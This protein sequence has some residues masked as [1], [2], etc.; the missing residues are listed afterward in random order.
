VAW[1]PPPARPSF[2]A[3]PGL[4][5]L[6]RLRGGTWACPY[7]SVRQA[8][9]GCDD[10]PPSCSGYVFLSS[11]YKKIEE[12]ENEVQEKGAE[13]T[14]GEQQPWLIVCPF[15]AGGHVVERP[16]HCW[17]E[18]KLREFL[19]VQKMSDKW[20]DFT[21]IKR[22]AVVSADVQTSGENGEVS[23]SGC[24]SSRRR[25][26]CCCCCCCREEGMAETGESASRKDRSV[27]CLSSVK[28]GKKKK[29][30]VGWFSTQWRKP[31]VPCY[32]NWVS[33]ADRRS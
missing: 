27:K 25:C 31:S 5:Q 33:W 26:S 29:K 10:G 30:V 8:S 13:N 4:L 18:D 11:P 2:P 15:L 3:F 7:T 12:R 19:R 20:R 32:I 17:A 9:G 21:D 23:G 22:L 28:K 1:L 16:E 14:Q 24:C 6:A